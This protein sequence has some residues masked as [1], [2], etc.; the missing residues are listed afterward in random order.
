MKYH[1]NTKPHEIDV[2][3]M[4]TPKQIAQWEQVHVNSV[5]LWIKNGTLKARRR[6]YRTIRIK[7]KDYLEFSEK[8]FNER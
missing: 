2:D 4:L 1:E 5:L 7:M 6:G 8:D 3:E